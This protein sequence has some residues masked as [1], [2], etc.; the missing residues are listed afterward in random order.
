M[1]ENALSFGVIVYQLFVNFVPHALLGIVFGYLYYSTGNLWGPFMAHTIINSTVNFI[2][3]RSSL[4]LDK[5]LSIRM[6]VFLVVMLL[7]I[8]LIHWISKTYNL[9]ELTKWNL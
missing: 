3:I 8:S 2:H 4:G 7:S 6:A 1:N 9:P 5:N